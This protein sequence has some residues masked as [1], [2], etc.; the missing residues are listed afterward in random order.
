MKYLLCFLCLLGWSQ[1]AVL[2]QINKI[3]TVDKSKYALLW[4]I[5]GKDLSKPTY[6]F[7]SMHLPDARVFELIDSVLITLDACEA[8]AAEVDLDSAMNMSDLFLRYDSYFYGGERKL[9]LGLHEDVE[10]KREE[11]KDYLK[12][13]VPRPDEPIKK[14]KKS[15]KN[16]SKYPATVDGKKNTET[17]MYD[18]LRSKPT[19]KN[20]FLDSYL[21]YLAKKHGK[22]ICGLEE[23]EKHFNMYG[24]RMGGSG[25]KDSAFLNLSEKE[26]YNTMLDYYRSGDLAKIAKFAGELEGDSIMVL[27]NHIMV[28]SILRITQKST[29]FSVMGCAHLIGEEGVINIFRK[30]G[31]TVRP[32]TAQFTQNVDTYIFKS[33]KKTITWYEN[34]QPTQGFSIE[35]PYKAN[36]RDFSFSTRLGIHNPF[37]NAK[38]YAHCQDVFT[39][40]LYSFGCIPIKDTLLYEKII[41][42]LS[43]V[44]QIKLGSHQKVSHGEWKGFEFVIMN[45][46]D[47]LQA[48]KMR[49]IEANNYRYTMTVATRTQYM[50]EDYITRFF[51][52][53]KI[54]KVEK[55]KQTW[56]DKKGAFAVD[57]HGYPLQNKDKSQIE[58]DGTSYVQTYH[59][60]KNFQDSTQTQDIV[61]YRDMIDGSIIQSD[62]S[63]FKMV[64]EYIKEKLDT[65]YT[66]VHSTFQGYPSRDF[67]VRAGKKDIRIK[68]CLRGNRNYLIARSQPIGRQDS[69]L[70]T[71]FHFSPFAPFNLEKKTQKE[72]GFTILLPK[73]NFK[74]LHEESVPYRNDIFEETYTY[75]STDENTGV[76]FWANS[77]KYSKYSYFENHDSL[78]QIAQ[79]HYINPQKDSLLPTPTQA[80]YK[81][82]KNKYANIY[83]VLQIKYQPDG[84]YGFMMVLPKELLKPE[85]IDIFMNSVEFL[86]T[87]AD[88]NINIFKPKTT[89]LWAD[90]QTKDSLKYV[91]AKTF[92]R[93]YKFK[94]QDKELLFQAF[95][96]SYL[97]DSLKMY[98]P[99]QYILLDKIDDLLAKDITT[100]DI[101]SLKALY[102][103][104]D[105]IL[106][107][108]RILAL[109]VRPKTQASIDIF[110]DLLKHKESEKLELNYEIMKYLRDTLPLL[111]NN[112]EKILAHT[113]KKIFQRLALEIANNLLQNNDSI[114]NPLVMNNL[115]KFT[116]FIELNKQNTDTL[117]H[118]IL[119]QQFMDLANNLPDAH[120]M[121]QSVQQILKDEVTGQETRL[122]ALSF[123]LKKNYPILPTELQT[124][125]DDSTSFMRCLETLEE[126]KKLDLVPQKH[127]K[128]AL[129]A[130]NL[131]YSRIWQKTRNLKYLRTIQIKYEGKRTRFY[132][133]KDSSNEYYQQ[134]IYVGGFR[135]GKHDFYPELME[136]GSEAI[137][138]EQKDSFYN[139]TWLSEKVNKEEAIPASESR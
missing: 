111:E 79:A 19:D 29:L 22:I 66:Q 138:K 114:P 119:H 35:T 34:R 77:F 108:P 99:I 32:V 60:Y 56:E 128:Q 68:S 130:K 76:N 100:Q 10:N 116:K 118:T 94:K 126:H 115:T 59:T 38:E 129:I 16:K 44:K 81:I 55:N 117:H 14:R 11:E 103:K 92:L 107:K 104:K 63:M 8:F 41:D 47:T 124:L 105:S 87:K 50:E 1:R 6:V 121:M 132:I 90:L 78:V 93:N 62:S 110:L 18:F 46:I 83:K 101:E 136:I 109:I 106:Y 7:G 112:F 97:D 125:L 64:E 71:S 21:A 84:V 86:P 139:A 113:D 123:L 95:E 53:L 89:L 45:E 36:H 37:A 91:K 54:F 33:P 24:G 9:D 49:F 15:K 3:D 72:A 2:A 51:N 12:V 133:F 137:D 61:M 40:S 43:K 127:R 26:I 102:L 57:M 48:I 23:L 96:R 75:N 67:F 120:D 135:K 13:E 74:K 80:S 131:A 30:K 70:F 42:S 5:S 28:N 65:A 58:V 122:Q 39:G 98:E 88:T 20:T 27:R 52:S 134:I 82:F 69:S 4:E 17:D 31:Y 85:H 25:R 73:G